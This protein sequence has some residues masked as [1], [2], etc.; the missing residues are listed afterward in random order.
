MDE[1]VRDPWVIDDK[2]PS[3]GKKAVT[4]R[5][6]IDSYIEYCRR[7]NRSDATLEA[8]SKT[9]HAW[10][11]WL[12]NRDMR[13]VHRQMIMDHVARPRTR[14]AQG[15]PGAPATQARDVSIFRN[16]YQWMRDEGHAE[17]NP[18]RNL[19]A[20]TVH[21]RNPRPVPDTDWRG[22]WAWPG[23]APRSRAFLGLGYICG[24]RRIELASVTAAHVT[25]TALVNLRRKGGGEHTL[26]WR[27]AATIVNDARPDLLPDVGVF[28]DALLETAERNP[29]GPLLGFN[30]DLNNVNKKLD[31]LCKRARVERFTPHQMRHSCAHNLVN[32]A[33]VPLPLVMEL[34]NHSDINVTMRY[35]RAGGGELDAWA[36]RNIDN[37]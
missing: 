16:F 35:V 31:M 27:T 8:Y 5:E 7:R 14:R 10:A 33:S 11:L 6:L 29:T 36:L 1:G 20:P 18:A 22:L 9:L 3:R 17:K 25:D 26:N 12:G 2:R 23:L 19:Q 13:T 21:N 4:N 28:A 37:S 24:L 32:E 34:M 15:Q 30:G